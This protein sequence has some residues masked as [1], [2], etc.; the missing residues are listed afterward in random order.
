MSY[1]EYSSYLVQLLEKRNFAIDIVVREIL[2][3]ILRGNSI[4][5]MG[6]GGSASTAEHFET[7][8]SFVKSGESVPNVKVSALTSNSSLITAI[9]NDLGFEYVFSH[10]LRR[11]ANSGDICILISASGNSSNLLKAIDE[12][13]KLNLITLGILGFDG[14]KL[15][16]LVD[17]SI[18]VETEIGKYGPVED[19]H[20]SICH[21]I[22]AM[23]GKKL[24]SMNL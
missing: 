11:K 20:L 13:R 14:G 1:S 19:L 12:A 8:L 16:N 18:I 23:V 5:I 10:Q 7:D 22:S 17:H 2:S 24:S 6:N 9:A 3:G 21:E 15:A 4:W